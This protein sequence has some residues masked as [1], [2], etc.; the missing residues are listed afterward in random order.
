MTKSLLKSIFFCG[1]LVFAA[2]RADAQVLYGSIVGTVR[3]GSGAAVPGAKV[4][5]TNK[6]TGQLR[7]ALANDTGNYNFVAVQP[8]DYEVRIAKEGFKSGVESNV[9]VT[10]NSTVR[11]DMA[12]AVGQV[13]ES[14]TIEA[15]AAVLQTDSAVVKSE[16]TN[17]DLINIPT[18]VGR[19]YQNLLITIPG[20]APP[21][22]AHSVPTNPSRALQFNVNGAPAAGN[23]IRIDGASSIQV[24]LP[25]IAAYV[26]SLEA[27]ETVN[28][29]TNSFSAEQGLAGGAAVNVQIKSGTNDLHGSGFWY[30][31]S[32]AMLAKPFTF[33]LLQQNQ[34]NPKYIFNQPGGTIGGRIIKNKLFYFAAY[35]ASTRREFANNVATLPTTGMRGGN[36]SDGQSIYGARGVIFDPATG[37]PNTGADR[38]PFPG[39]VIPANRI[40]PIAL[41]IQQRIPAITEAAFRDNNYFATG[42]FL[43]D[44]HTLDTKVNYNIN[45]KWTA[46]GRYSILNYKMNNPGMLGDIVGPGISGAGGNT[47]NADGT[48][49][50]ATIASTYVIRPNLIVDANFGY[51]LYQTG[52]EQPFLDQNI[53]RDVLRIPGTNGTRRF[54]GG[55]PRFQF[56][57]F[58]T[59]GVPDSFMPYTRRDPQYQYVFNVNWT[60]GRHQFR[61]GIDFYK[62]DLNHLQA[63]FAGQNQG[64]QG[65]F[66]F[67]GGPTQIRGGAAASPY[68]TWASFLLGLPNSFGT[69]LQVPDEYGTRT[70]LYSAY[71]QDTWQVN[72]KLTINIGTRYENIPMPRRE[73]RGM[74]RYDFINNKMLVCGVGAV[75]TDCGTKN[76]NLLFSPRVGIAYR[77]NEKTVIRTGFGINWDPL[78][79]VR[80]LRTNYPLL[81]ILNGNAPDAFVPVSRLEQGIPAPTVPNLGNGVLDIPAT[82]ALTSTGDSFRRAYI[83]S[84]NFTVQRQLAN[85]FTLQT[86]YVANRTVRQ[87]NFLDLNAGQIIGTGQNGRPFFPNFRRNVQTGLV[88][89]LGHTVYDSL[90][91]SMVKRTN[92]G[93]TWNVAYTWSKA[94]GVCC[95]TNN[96]GGPAIQALPFLGL[97]R[98]LSPFD[99]PHNLQT[100]VVWELPFGKGKSLATSGIA[101]AILGGWQINTLMSGFTGSPFTVGADGASLNLPGSTQRADLVGEVQRLGGAGRGQAFFDYRAFRNVTEQR[102]GTAGFNIVRGP[103]IFN[104][105]AGLFRRFNVNERINIQFRAELANVLNTPQLGNPSAGIQGLRTDPAGNFQGGVFEITGVANTGRDGIVQRAARLGLRIAF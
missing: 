23:N 7:E 101:S 4:T 78:N 12:L 42:G 6:A 69:T 77:P 29:V 45:E 21:Q 3:D 47:G 102:F 52:V 46:Y 94:L 103:H 43:F 36:F 38:T 60:K 84:W 51:T 33:M 81:I 28:V 105:D 95:N 9:T 71:F 70:W 37:D 53:G 65:G 64:A 30:H 96:D 54:E 88:D 72:Q 14:V 39:N 92:S 83:M 58:T 16:V 73:N 61:Y 98:A 87:T 85:G 44:R 89:S 31:N 48:T 91:V 74:E 11:V 15:S 68:N 20:V 62:Q 79:L 10:A 26:P 99:R 24:W 80:A 35:E 25:H 8:G 57:G 34:R 19:N 18:P 59:L 76:S 13:N 1:L 56:G 40:S 41:A 17:K 55:W 86:G 49:H 93:L 27:I 2:L 5:A 63:E 66:S 32:N 100:T 67:T 82:Y 22:N 50:S 90:Q 104:W 97:A 75:P